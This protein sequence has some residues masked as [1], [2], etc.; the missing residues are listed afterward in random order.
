MKGYCYTTIAHYYYY[1]YLSVFVM[2]DVAN[3]ANRLLFC[4]E[5][6]SLMAVIEISIE[7]PAVG[8]QSVHFI[9]W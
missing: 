9:F 8:F 5:A 1:G 3:I 2:H 4:Y 6:E 7:F